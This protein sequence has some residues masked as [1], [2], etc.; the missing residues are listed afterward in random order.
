MIAQLERRSNRFVKLIKWVNDNEC[1]SVSHGNQW[2]K[3][4]TLHE[5]LSSEHPVCLFCFFLPIDSFE[6]DV[7]N[8][9]A[10]SLNS[11]P[12]YRPRVNV[13]RPNLIGL[14]MGEMDLPPRGNVLYMVCN[15]ALCM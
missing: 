2:D 14:T 10:P 8:P 12:V 6:P 5:G 4:F 3:G 13:Q 15:H 7:Y 9:E 1:K 11:R